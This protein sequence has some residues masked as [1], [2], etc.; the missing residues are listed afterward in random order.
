MGRRRTQT[1][2]SPRAQ[3]LKDGNR[4]RALEIA[5]EYQATAPWDV[6]PEAWRAKLVER[7][8]DYFANYPKTL[9][10]AGL[11]SDRKQIDITVQAEVVQRS[12][13]QIQ[14]M[15]AQLML[16]EANDLARA[17]RRAPIMWLVGLTAEARE[18]LVGTPGMIELVQWKGVPWEVELPAGAKRAPPQ[19]EGRAEPAR[20]VVDAVV[21]RR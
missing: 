9:G 4:D 18:L 16:D 6:D 7:P 10:A 12:S 20:R 11:A 19:I 1:T 2:L 13:S 17:T 8:F 3:A 21:K 5:A 14:D 15:S